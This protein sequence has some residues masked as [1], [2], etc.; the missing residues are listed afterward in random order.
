[1]RPRLLI[2]DEPTAPLGPRESRLLFA[3]IARL[4]AAGV[5]ILYVSHRFAEVLNLCDAVTVLRNGRHVITTAIHDWTEARLTEAMIGTAA[6]LYRRNVRPRGR[7]MLELRDVSLGEKLRGI[8]LDLH[9]GEIV[10]VTGLLGAGQNELGRVIGGDIVPDAGEIRVGGSPRRFAAPSDAVAA[11]I[12]LLTEERKLEG[13]LPNRTLREN[14]GIGSL[15][16]LAGTAGLVRAAREGAATAAAAKAL[17]IVAASSETPIRS[18]SGGNQQKALVA[19]WHLADMEVFVL[20][21]P[22]RGVDVGARADIYRRLDEL[23]QAGKAVLFVSSDIAEVL[24]LA[25][26]I[27]VVRSGGI[28][29]ETGAGDLG[30]EA[31]NLLVQGAAAA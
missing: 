11:G 4:K 20:I 31:L 10:G 23:A 3:A 14:I 22:T 25:D 21:E 5:A 16:R 15:R 17:G 29:A 13:I 30:E 27:L 12:C 9:R 26:R 8:S 24:T 28:A 2:L 1:M 19:R 18:L 7:V 6:E